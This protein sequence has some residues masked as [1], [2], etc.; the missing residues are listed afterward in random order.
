[1]YTC[2]K[3]AATYLALTCDL[4]F[5]WAGRAFMRCAS[6]VSRAAVGTHVV[7]KETYD[8]K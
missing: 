6:A 3:H 5:C 8:Y 4:G 1:M 2:C 7:P